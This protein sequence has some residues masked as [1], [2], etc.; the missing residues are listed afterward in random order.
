MGDQAG[1][2]LRLVAVQ[3]G[4]EGI[5][6]ARL[7]EPGSGQAMGGLPLGDRQEGG[8]P[9]ADVGARVVVAQLK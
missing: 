2:P 6:V 7:Q 4:I 9:L 3:P 8:A 5:R 1:D